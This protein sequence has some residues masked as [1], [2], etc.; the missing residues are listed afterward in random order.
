MSG[1]LGQDA[2]HVDAWGSVMLERVFHLGADGSLLPMVATPYPTAHQLNSLVQTHPEVVA[3]EQMSTQPRRWALVLGSD[4]GTTGRQGVSLFVDQEAVPT[5]VSTRVADDEAQ[6]RDAIGQILDLAANGLQRWP[7]DELRATFE[8]TQRRAGFNPETVLD[9]LTEDPERF[10]GAVEGNLAAGRIRMVLVGHDRSVELRRI[11]ELLND[12]LTPAEVYVVE[13]THY[14]N[15]SRGGAVLVPGVPGRTPITATHLATDGLEDEQPPSSAPETGQLVRLLG[16]LAE[17]AGLDLTSSPHT[18]AVSMGEGQVLASVD[19]EWGTFS[20]SLVHL[21]LDDAD[22]VLRVLAG[23]TR[24]RLDAVVPS[25]PAARVVDRWPEVRDLVVR[26][27]SGPQV[28]VPSARPS[29]DS[30]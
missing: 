22:E 30:A 26:L 20:M 21:G 3:S 9:G 7:V 14:V 29:S 17:N 18:V 19:V 23:L 16:E 11:A 28:S 8:T 24:A 5:L 15:A 1:L 10:F 4:A 27:A 13:L 12:Q 6:R 2:A 25:V